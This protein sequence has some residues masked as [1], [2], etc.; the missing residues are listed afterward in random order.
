MKKVYDL[1][2]KIS[3]NKKVWQNIG[4]VMEN[5]KGMFLLLDK[6]FN[7]AGIQDGKG[8]VLVNM[9]KPRATEY[10]QQQV[11]EDFGPPPNLDNDEQIPF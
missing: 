8:S 10:E 4:V 2:V 9:F 3:G 1:V 7:P 5:E 11:T 6:T